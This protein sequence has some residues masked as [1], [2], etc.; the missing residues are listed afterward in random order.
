L[1]AAVSLLAAALGQR[2]L[3]GNHSSRQ[4]A[5]FDRG[6]M[7][8]GS[9]DGSGGGELAGCGGYDDGGVQLWGVRVN[10]L[11]LLIDLEV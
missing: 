8:D 11:S 7:H 2:Q 4:R 5:G 3:R 10:R 1:L 6:W 9:W